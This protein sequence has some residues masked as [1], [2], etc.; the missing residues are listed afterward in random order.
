MQRRI[1][2]EYDLLR[3]KGW[4]ADMALRAARTLVSFRRRECGEHDEPGQFACVRLRCVPDEYCTLEDLYG[5]T[6][7]PQVN[8]SIPR[9]RLERER[10]EFDKR[11]QREGVWGIIAEYYDAVDKCWDFAD[12]LFGIIGDETSEEFLLTD[13]KWSALRERTLSVR[14]LRNLCR[15]AP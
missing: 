5:D 13:L 2:R 6:F 10:D 14:K 3:A 4:S 7:N 1:K 8:P 9:S 12:S 11:V 15:E